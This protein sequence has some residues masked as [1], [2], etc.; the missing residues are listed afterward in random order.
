MLNKENTR[1]AETIAE[2][3]KPLFYRAYELGAIYDKTRERLQKA[4]AVVD[5]YYYTTRHDCAAA[6]LD[7]D[8]I[9]ELKHNPARIKEWGA[10]YDKALHQQ[11]R[12]EMAH[13]VA[14]I[15]FANYINYFADLVADYIRPNWQELTKRGGLS[16]FADIINKHARHDHTAGAV[17]ISLYLQDVGN[18]WARVSVSIC[19]GWACGVHGGRSRYYQNNPGEVWHFAELPPV[20][21][22]AKFNAAQLKIKKIIDKAESIR[23]ECLQVAKAAG[24]LGFVEI[25]GAINTTK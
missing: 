18:D 21:D 12:A 11:S 16:T 13:N 2:E 10:L 24:V 17:S 8:K 4:G 15:N 5:A 14:A 9:Q 25:I 22:V 1:R 23:A 6:G 3:L 20:L 19:P 7:F